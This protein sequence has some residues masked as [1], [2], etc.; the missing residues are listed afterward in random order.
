M[1]SWGYLAFDDDYS[2][3]WC[4]E[5]ESHTDLRLAR[6]TLSRV[7]DPAGDLGSRAGNEG[8][9]AAEILAIC[10]GHGLSVVTPALSRWISSLSDIPSD[11]DLTIAVAAVD[12]VL[13]DTSE[14]RE[15]WDE[16]PGDDWL[17]YM[18]GMRHRLSITGDRDVF[19]QFANLD[20]DLDK[21]RAVDW[22]LYFDNQDAALLGCRSGRG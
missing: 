7:A 9:A 22:F 19:L 12:R 15:L 18:E 21:P 1:G 17:R 6:S 3:D 10:I 8:V 14:L 11:D 2:A 13:S 16:Q 5:L 4:N 20:L